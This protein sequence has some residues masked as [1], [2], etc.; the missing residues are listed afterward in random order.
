M[1]AAA[2]ELVP[3][4]GGADAGQEQGPDPGGLVFVLQVGWFALNLD[5]ET[6]GAQGVHINTAKPVAKG[7]VSNTA[8]MGLLAIQGLEAVAQD[9]HGVIVLAQFGCQ[10]QQRQA[11]I[12]RA[13]VAAGGVPV[14]AAVEQAD[15]ITE[16]GRL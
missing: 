7:V 9:V 12:E 8:E 15:A 10:V 13:Q 2:A 4:E 5:T 11:V 1:P 6:E 3:E 16:Q 14:K